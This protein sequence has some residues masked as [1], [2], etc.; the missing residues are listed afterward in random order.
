MPVKTFVKVRKRRNITVKT[1]LSF[2]FTKMFKCK[3]VKN[4]FLAPEREVDQN[5]VTGEQKMFD[6]AIAKFFFESFPQLRS[7]KKERLSL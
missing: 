4:K 2:E 1:Y 3:T 5:L 6:L 7:P